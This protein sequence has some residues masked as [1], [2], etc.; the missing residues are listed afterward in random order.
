ME[1]S[2]RS[3]AALLAAGDRVELRYNAN[4]RYHPKPKPRRNLGFE[5]VFED[6]HLIVVNKPAELLTVPTRARRNEHAAR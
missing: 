2:L 3:P 1:R 6:K 5:I 4:Q